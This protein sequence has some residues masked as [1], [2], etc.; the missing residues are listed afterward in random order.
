MP[1]NIVDT[2]DRSLAQWQAQIT[3]AYSQGAA[4]E[5]AELLQ[6]AV[7]L[8]DSLLQRESKLESQRLALELATADMLHQQARTHRQRRAI[9][10]TMRAQK[11]EFALECERLRQHLVE[12]A[13]QAELERMQQVEAEKPDETLDTKGSLLLEVELQDVRA[14]LERTQ[15]DLQETTLL[16]QEL[17]HIQATKAAEHK[18]LA[19][20]DEL[21]EEANRVS[22]AASDALLAD[23]ESRLAT[24]KQ[25]LSDLKDQNFDLAS[26]VAKHQVL[27]SGHSPHINFDSSTL[28]WE[29]RKQLIMRQLEEESAEDDYSGSGDATRRLEIE[30][31]IKTTQAEID[32]RD[33]EI[34]ELHTIIQQQSDTRQGV[35]IGA[36]AFAQAFDADEIIQQERQKLKEIQLQWEDKLRQAEIDVSLER[37]KLAR[38]R[39]Q[40]EQE[41]ETSLHERK[42][43]GTPPIESK[44]RKWLDHLGLRDE[45]RND[46]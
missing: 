13:E 23:L 42:S 46:K 19:E 21:S 6:T 15:L 39:T 2:L 44:K 34:A 10:Q 3:L 9:A 20:R 17:E 1:P 11:A 16:L 35:A 24:A 37:A 36:A 40:L 28:C 7:R 33:A 43:V 12:Q 32:H 25:E 30:T 29:E 18:E 26:Q 27:A 5:L 45:S 31:V 38:E 41:L 8:N 14:E 4:Q 22:S